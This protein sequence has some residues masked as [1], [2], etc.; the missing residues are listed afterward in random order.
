[1]KKE[2]ETTDHVIWEIEKGFVCPIANGADADEAVCKHVNK[3]YC[4]YA[5]TAH[6]KEAV[7][8]DLLNCP[9]DLDPEGNFD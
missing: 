8:K 6:L 5:S 9:Y 3:F 7:K 1:M 4:R 2:K